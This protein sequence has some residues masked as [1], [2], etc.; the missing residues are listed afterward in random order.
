[1]DLKESDEDREFRQKARDYLSA[2]SPGTPPD[3]GD[4][5]SAEFSKAWQRKLFEDGWAGV[6]WPQEYGGLGLSGWR[7]LIWMEEC[8]RSGAPLSSGACYTGLYHAG[9]TIMAR[10]TEE[11]KQQWLPK[12]LDGTHTWCQG[13]SEPGAGTDLANMRCRGELD[14]DHIVINGHKTWTTNGHLADYQEAVVRTEAGSQRHKGL[15]WLIVTMHADGVTVRPIKTMGGESE[16]N[17]TFY[18][19]VRVPVANVVGGVGNGWSTAMA[20]FAFERGIGFIPQYFKLTKRVQQVIELAET[21]Y[22]PSGKL[23][24]TDDSIVQRL[25]KVKAECIGLK[26][27]ILSGLA[28]IERRGEPG[29]EGS[30]VKV[31]ISTTLQELSRIARDIMGN[32]FLDYASSEHS[33]PNAY[34]YFWSWV[35]TVAGGSN[36]IQRDVIAD[37]ILG[38]PRAR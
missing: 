32:Q 30:I 11:Q 20:T 25:A 13:F 17:D 33:N 31:I 8:A 10:G 35:E 23:A 21:T 15:T 12:I 28:Q 27:M 24:S 26:A 29:A 36:E 2:N 3:R 38:L 14:G 37:R 5:A 16:T 7:Y 18:D 4:I 22:L 9:P 6:N 1:M 34:E 19:N